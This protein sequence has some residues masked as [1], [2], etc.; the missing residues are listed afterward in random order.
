MKGVQRTTTLKR[1]AAWLEGV[2]SST[3]LAIDQTHQLGSNV[4]VVVGRAVGVWASIRRQFPLNKKEDIRDATSHLGE[5]INRSASGAVKSRDLA[6]S[7]QKIDGSIWSTEIE[8][9]LTNL[10]RSY[11]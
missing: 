1:Y 6:V 10:V 3:V 9:T 7:T 5:K 4:A 2:A 8:P 11:L